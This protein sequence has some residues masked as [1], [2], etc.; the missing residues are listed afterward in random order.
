MSGG[1]DKSDESDESP[2]RTMD[3]STFGRLYRFGR[4]PDPTVVDDTW[5]NVG[6]RRAWAEAMAQLDPANPPADVPLARWQRFIDDCGRFLDQ[7]WANRAEALGWGLLVAVYTLMLMV[8]VMFIRC[9]QCGWRF[10]GGNR[11]GSCDFP[12]GAGSLAL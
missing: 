9:P 7:G 2:L 8:R 1:A 10:G 5:T 12:R 11:C 3:R 4:N 6:A